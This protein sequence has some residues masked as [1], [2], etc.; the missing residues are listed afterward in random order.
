MER[1]IIF[2]IICALLTG[3]IGIGLT[4]LVSHTAEGLIGDGIN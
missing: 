4:T 2:A 3:G 1:R